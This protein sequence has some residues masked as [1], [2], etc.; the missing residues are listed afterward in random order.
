MRKPMP[1]LDERFRLLVEEVRDYAI[2]ML[3]PE[4]F[5][6]SWNAG[7]EAI[8]GYKAEEII[9]QHFSGFYPAEAVERCVPD[10]EL[11]V[12]QAVGRFEDEGWRVRK[13]GSMF[14][15]NVVITALRDDDGKLRGFAKITRDLTERW[16]Q[17]ESLRE[18]EERFRLLVEGI[19]DYAIFMLDPE[20]HVV[21]W[22]AGAEAIKG[23]RAE[24]ILGQHFS[25]FYPEKDIARRWPWHE[26]KVARE[27]GRFEDEGWRVRKDG[28]M[29]WANV[30][31]T[32]LYD[33]EHRLRGFAKVTR[34][35][36]ERRRIEALEKADIRR[37]EFLAMLAHELRN[38]LAPIRNALGLLGPGRSDEATVEWSRGVIERQVAHLSRLV[39]DLLD[40][41]RITA[42]K[43]T[44][45]RA[46]VDIAQVVSVAVEASQPLI[47]EQGH[48]LEVQV[49]EE[50]VRVKGDLTRLAQVVLNLLN[51]AAKYT[52]K[53]GRIRLTVERQQ[54]EMVLRVRDNGI[55]I[56]PHLLPEIF[57]LFTQGD[58]ALDRPEGGLGIGLT[59][60]KRLVELHG[61][62]VQ[63]L[64]EG[65]DLGTEMVVRLPIL[66]GDLPAGMPK[67]GES[68]QASVTRRILVVDD[69]RD[70]TE[71]LALLLELW[72]HEVYSALDGPSALALAAEHRPEI[73]LLDIGLPGMTGYEVAQ[74]MRD[75][76]GLERVLLVAVTGYGQ[77]EDRRRTREAGFEYHLIK[78]V[79]PEK[80]RELIDSAF[81]E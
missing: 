66:A 70:A 18:S 16:R 80:L 26:L 60:V 33:R 47:Q 54:G 24:D 5:I 43:I 10:Y 73:V 39:D 11:K 79:E 65:P 58:R 20:G 52:P 46:P 6:V 71:T 76:P 42:N 1:E 61:G 55:G 30:V 77:Q 27:V 28:S 74:R 9:G 63:A 4:G 56:A 57:E 40:V 31:I 34:D 50:P 36:T 17:E 78:P 29:F 41:S 72:G 14:W 12:A 67:T 37:T 69:N 48:T 35:M 81:L 8:K 38:P 64:S 75:I 15:A 53:G 7:A 32:A 22:N 62:S 51:N 25:R 68:G 45:Q 21:S 44:L 49:P 3:D 59:L 19:R 13:D 23:Y 2:F